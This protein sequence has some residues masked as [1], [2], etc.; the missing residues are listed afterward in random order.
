MKR[1]SFLFEIT[2]I[3]NHLQIIFNAFNIEFRGFA[4]LKTVDSLT[5]P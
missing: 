5:M 2:L 4:N 3:Y 1:K